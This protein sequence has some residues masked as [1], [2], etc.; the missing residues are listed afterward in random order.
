MT[1]ADNPRAVAGSNSEGAEMAQ[2]RFAK[3]HLKAYI[4]RVENRLQEKKEIGDDIRDIYAEAKAH[5]FDTATMRRVIKLREM[6][7]DERAE[8]EMLLDTYCN[9]LGLTG[10]FL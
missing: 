4:E 7:A 6:D 3:D 9:A 2:T 10:V 5:G 8:A 1:K